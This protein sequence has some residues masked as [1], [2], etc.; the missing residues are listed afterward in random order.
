MISPTP[1]FD[2]EKL[3]QHN[4]AAIAWIRYAYLAAADGGISKGYDLLRRRW[5][6]SYPE[7][8]GYTIP[9]L[10]NAAKLLEYP[11]LNA[12]AISLAEYLL[13]KAALDG[14]VVHWR[15][16]IDASPIVFDTGQVMFGWL[17]V[18]RAYQDERFLQA[19]IRSGNWLVTIQDRDGSWKNNQYLN[20]VKVIDTRVAWALLELYQITRDETYRQAAIRNLDWASQQQDEAGWFNKCSFVV[21]KPPYTH[22]LAYTAEGLFECG[23]ILDN[24]FYKTSAR[25]MADAVLSRHHP[26]GSLAGTYGPG[27]QKHSHWSCLTGNCQIAHLWLRLFET[28]RELKYYR[29]AQ[30]AVFFVAHTQNIHT[31]N[32]NIRGA[33]AGSHPRY[34]S[35]ERFKYPNWAAKFFIDAIMK[36]EEIESGKKEILYVG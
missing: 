24:E 3:K 36:L 25:R 5:A 32:P 18:Y 29:A 27:F 9:T 10:L 4:A 30:K 12:L 26:D 28:M 7:T 6:P 14:G 34:G 8:T 15:T 1:E 19:A 13:E 11:E 23:K 21:G 31:K 35:Y 16:K 33:I 20:V 22:T 17:A 2:V